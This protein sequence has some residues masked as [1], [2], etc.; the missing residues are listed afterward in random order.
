MVTIVETA[1]FQAQTKGL[2]NA[3]ERDALFDRLARNPAT[4]DLLV[5][6]NG[7][8]KVRVA[9]S[10][11]GKSGGGRVITF[12]RDPSLPLF[13]LAYFAKSQKVNLSQDELNAL[14]KLTQTLVDRYGA[15]G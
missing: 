3:H 11:R 2:L 4:G 14:A 7:L 5:G 9:R 8:R 6:G 15:F 10:G 13:L 1:A 12:F